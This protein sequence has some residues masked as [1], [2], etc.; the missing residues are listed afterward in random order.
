MSQCKKRTEVNLER[1]I[2]AL[3]CIGALSSCVTSSKDK[4]VPLVNSDSGELS[5]EEFEVAELAEDLI[6]KCF[7]AMDVNDDVPRNIELIAMA[8]INCRDYIRSTRSIDLYELWNVE[9]HI[10]FC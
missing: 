8:L 6:S 10:R 5:A 9:L 2:L 7:L 4:T 1:L 3:I